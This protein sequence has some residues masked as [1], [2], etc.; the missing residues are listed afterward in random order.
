MNRS[1]LAGAVAVLV[2]GCGSSAPA[3]TPKGTIGGRVLSAPSC[4][5]QQQGVPCPPRPVSSAAVVVFHAGH[6]IASTHTD[7]QGRFRLTVSVGRCR[8]RA[9]NVGGLATTASKVVVVHADQ[10]V[11]VRLVVDSGIR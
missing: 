11:R 10:V 5:V 6:V 1:L 2:A 8:V 4:P 9:T 7:T 3:A